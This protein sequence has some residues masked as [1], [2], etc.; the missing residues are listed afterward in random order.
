M[1]PY[2]TSP[3]NELD[4]EWT[5]GMLRWPQLYGCYNVDATLN[6][7]QSYVFF[8]FLPLN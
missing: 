5:L 2:F 6:T 7:N 3:L 8:L 4:D 1:T